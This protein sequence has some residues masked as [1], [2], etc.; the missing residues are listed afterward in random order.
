MDKDTTEVDVA[1]DKALGEER[2]FVA[3]Y[4]N[5]IRVAAQAIALI[6]AFA[7]SLE[8]AR[9][10]LELPFRGVALV[11]G[12][13]ILVVGYK[14]ERFLTK[15]P[16]AI[17][18]FD[19]PNLYITLAL[20]LTYT[21]QQHAGAGLALGVMLFLVVL[22]VLSLHQLTISL[23]ALGGAAAV[24]ALSQQARLDGAWLA[25]SLTLIALAAAV[26]MI[27][28]WRIR[29]LVND[30]STEQARRAKLS[31]YFS[32]QVADR[33]AQLGSREAEHRE[34]SVLMSDIRGFTSMSEN[35]DSRAV[36]TLLNEYLTRMVDVIFAHGGT[37]DKFIG[38]GILAYFGAPVDQT[39]HA[40]RAIACGLGMLE[41]LEELN[42][43]RTAR[44][45][46]R[47]EIGIGIHTGKAHV[48]E[49]G[50][51]SRLEYTVI[52][53]TVNLTSRIE[54]LC[55]TH[56]VSVLASEAAR[57]R[58]EGFEWQA[59][60]PV[61]VKGQTKPVA[62]FVPSRGASTPPS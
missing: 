46:A 34:V 5:W 16:L 24:F 1:F 22:A 17:A 62:T 10:L 30:V 52:G 18:I 2:R 21:E 4:L 23:T 48:G 20:A 15:S 50:S 51:E 61:P 27:V 32:P 44:G 25:T 19:V 55:K 58:A 26:G 42:R 53:D 39:D 6:A 8:A 36:V 35:M 38:D 43:L 37:L 29:T 49:I 7:T 28:A 13:I 3:K 33:I 41:S 60:D 45:D 14:S 54:A 31:R 47:L 57:A 9:G 56:G 40:E 59:A 12:I 11:I